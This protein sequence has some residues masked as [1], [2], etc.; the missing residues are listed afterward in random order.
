M[1]TAT[2]SGP[3]GSLQIQTTTARQILLTATFG[4][5]AHARRRPAKFTFSGAAGDWSMPGTWQGNVFT[6]SRPLD[7]RGVASV[8]GLL[9]GGTAA[10]SAGSLRVGSARLPPSSA[11]GS[12]WVICPKQMMAPS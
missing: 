6:S 9:G 8:L 4:P 2:A 5:A 12:A 10:V 7:E 11:E 3:G 1:C